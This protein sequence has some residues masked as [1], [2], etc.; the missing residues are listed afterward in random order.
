MFTGQFLRM[1]AGAENR[2][3][4]LLGDVYKIPVSDRHAPLGALF[5]DLQ[6]YV[7]RRQVNLHDTIEKF[8]DELFPLVYHNLLNDPSVTQLDDDYR[9]CLTEARQQLNPRP[10]GDVPHRLSHTLSQALFSAR[11]FLEALHIGVDAINTTEKIVL[12]PQCIKAIAK[13]RYCGQCDGHIGARPCR[14][15]CY[16]VMRGCLATTAE[17]DRH[18]NEFVDSIKMLTNYMQGSYNIEEVLRG[19]H[20]RISEAIMHS[21]ETGHKFYAKVGCTF[22]YLPLSIFVHTICLFCRIK[23]IF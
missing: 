19:L 6:A 23:N 20:T 10:F 11:T 5:A 1:I 21:M 12:E 2:T 4:Q 9:E 7:R 18:W 15:F 3:D 14:N 16:N 13:L 22:L 17:I 8:F